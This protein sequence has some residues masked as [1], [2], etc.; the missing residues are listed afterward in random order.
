MKE[1]EELELAFKSVLA[2][3]PAPEGF[4]LRVMARLES[5]T[6]ASLSNSASAMSISGNAAHFAWVVVPYEKQLPVRSF[7]QKLV[8]WFGRKQ[9]DTLALGLFSSSTASF[10]N[11]TW[12]PLLSAIIHAVVIAVIVLLAA[13]APRVVPKAQ[14]QLASVE[15]NLPNIVLPIGKGSISGGGGG[16][17]NQITPPSA[18]RLPQP[19][20]VTIPVPLLSSNTAPKLEVPPAVIAPMIPES[21]SLPNLGMPLQMAVNLASNG[22]GSGGGIGTGRGGGV[23]DGSGSG[24][25]SGEGGGYG[26]GLYH[27]GNGVTAPVLIHAVDPEF[28]DEA[29]RAK[30]QGVSMVSLIVD[31]TGKPVNL[32]IVRRLGMGLDEKALEAVKQYRFHPA[33]F[34]GKPVPVA[35]SVEVN[36]R[37]Y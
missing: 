16:G 30:Y 2:P 14:Q 22:S 31:A 33:M 1:Q 37:I 15:M 24:I 9:D 29:R 18:G 13:N 19:Q 32:K 23:G 26:G 34:H 28:S 7:W 8:S 21:S 11:S 36:F 4:A 5:R 3:Q 20:K 35:I 17:A 12:Q 27:I 6:G 25:G 10:E